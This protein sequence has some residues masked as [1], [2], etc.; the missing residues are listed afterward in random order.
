[1][2]EVLKRRYRLILAPS[3]L[4]LLTVKNQLKNSFLYGI[5]NIFWLDKLM[6][7]G[8][9]TPKMAVEAGVKFVLVGHSERKQYLQ[10]NATV[11]N[12][13]IKTCFSHNLIPIICVGEKQKTDE[14]NISFSLK[15]EIFEELNYS[16]R[17][18]K[19]EPKNK[20][21]IAYEPTWAINSGVTPSNKRIQ[22][23]TQLIR[24]WL[25]RR[26]S[27]KIGLSIPIL[28]GGSIDHHNVK[29]I[30]LLKDVNGILI[31][32]AS[33]NNQ[34]LKQIIKRLIKN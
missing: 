3:A 19:L 26:F 28:Y 4:H 12:H 16:F 1:M 9:I 10:E 5:Q 18:I 14:N 8:E 23:I 20:L 29:E 11:I 27:E 7:T 2:P 6:V 33:S 34:K 24:F 31:G 15:Q 22:E 21:I 32:S 25:C 30:L 17:G 13:K